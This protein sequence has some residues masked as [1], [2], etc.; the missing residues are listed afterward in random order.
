[1]CV[2][3]C[4]WW[5]R[6]RFLLLL[7]VPLLSAHDGSQ[8]DADDQEEG[9]EGEQEGED[10]VTSP[11]GAPRLARARCGGWSSGWIKSWSG[12]IEMLDEGSPAHLVWG[13]CLCWMRPP[14]RRDRW[15]PGPDHVVTPALMR[16]RRNLG[17]RGSWSWNCSPPTHFSSFLNCYIFYHLFLIILKWRR[18][19]KCRMREPIFTSTS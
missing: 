13:R 7:Q 2:P 8:G 10:D 12:I 19:L 4:W 16:S 18:P 9:G 1:M 3:D 17:T 11:G 6:L 5:H 14:V 15:G